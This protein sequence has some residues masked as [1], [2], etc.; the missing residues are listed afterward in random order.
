MYREKGFICAMFRGP[1]NNPWLFFL[2]RFVAHH[3]YLEN[4][5]PVK[6]VGTRYKKTDIIFFPKITHSA[7]LAALIP[8]YPLHSRRLCFY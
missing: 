3:K 1:L 4:I 6:E 8:S 5:L 7:A 2:F